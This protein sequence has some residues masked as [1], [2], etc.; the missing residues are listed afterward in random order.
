MGVGWEPMHPCGNLHPQ[1]GGRIMSSGFECCES[2]RPAFTS[3]LRTAQ[4]SS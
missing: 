3:Q 4:N 1:F 2:G